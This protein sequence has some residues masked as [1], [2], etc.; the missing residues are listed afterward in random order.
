MNTILEKFLDIKEI[1]NSFDGLEKKYNWLLTDFDGGYT[2]NLLDYVEDYRNFEEGNNCLDKFWIKG[3]NL[4]RLANRK[5]FYPIWGVFSAFD[6]KETIDL[7][8]NKEEPFADG[9][10]NFWVENP[11]IQHPKAVVELVFWDSSLILLLSKDDDFSLNFRNTFQGW[12]DL[13]SYNQS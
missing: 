3:E 10:P 5:E 4:D 7:D 11:K 8:D 12:K 6:K 9:N 13:N 1:L 2:E